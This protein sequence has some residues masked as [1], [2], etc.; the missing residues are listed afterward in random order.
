LLLFLY[1]IT[2]FGPSDKFLFGEVEKEDYKGLIQFGKQQQICICFALVCLFSTLSAIT[3]PCANL[4]LLSF[5]FSN[6][7]MFGKMFSI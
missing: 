2:N 5:T 7:Q 4:P 6:K 1:V 3:P